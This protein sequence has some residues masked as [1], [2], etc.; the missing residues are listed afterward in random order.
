[1]GTPFKCNPLIGAAAVGAGINLLGGLFG[2]SQQSAFT[3]E[4][5]RLQSKLNREE[6]ALSAGIERGNA[7]WLM[8]RQYQSQVSGMK[9]AGLN[10]ATANGTTPATPS[11]GT[12]HSGASG[13]SASMPNLDL[14][15]AAASVANLEQQNELLKAQTDKTKSEKSNIDADTVIKQ[16]QGSPKYQKLVENGLSADAGLAWANANLSEKKA[17]ESMATVQK[18]GKDMALTDSQIN[19][20]QAETAKT[21]QDIQ[22][23]ISRVSL[24]KAE[25]Y[26]KITGASLNKALASQAHANAAEA[27]ERINSGLYKSEAARNNAQAK[28]AAANEDLLKKKG[29]TEEQ[30]KACKEIESKLLEFDQKVNEQYGALD[31]GSLQYAR[32]LLDLV[33]GGLLGGS[34]PRF[35]RSESFSTVYMQR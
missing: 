20:L 33:S 24:N 32:D 28:E 11:L 14:A 4:Q 17:F 1:M 12:P 15:G 7:E 2:G 13:P 6:M 26:F 8:N 22:E 5:Q 34:A 29:F 10:P 19:Q 3:K 9:N 25:K 18:I 21:Y 35:S 31:K 16:W 30:I 27:H 23:S